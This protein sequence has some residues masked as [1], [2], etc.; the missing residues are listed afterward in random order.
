MILKKIIIKNIRSYEEQEITFPKGSTLLSGN[1]GSG[2]TTV[3][4]AI[5]FA[6]FGLQPSQKAASLLRNDKDEGL[7]S[8]EL[9]IDGKD[10]RIDRLLKRSKKSISQDYSALTIEGQKYEESITEIK[11]KIL[12]LL[13]YPKEFSKK[14]NLLYK[15]TVYTP[16]EEMKQIILESNDLRLNTIRHVFGIDKYKRIEDNTTILISKLRELIKILDARIVFLENDKEILKQKQKNLEILKDRKELVNRDYLDKLDIVREKEESVLEIK[17]KIDEKRILETE[18]LKIDVLISEKNRQYRD[19]LDKSNLLRKEIH[20]DEKISIKDEDYDSIIRR[21]K[22]QVEKEREIQ[23]EYIDIISKINTEESKKNEALNL[24]NKIL[25]LQK[26]PICLQNISDEY[27]NNI[28]INSDKEFK[29]AN[30]R[31][32]ELKLSKEQ[33][34]SKIEELKKNLDDLRLKKS[35]MEILRVRIENIIEKKNR[36]TELETQEANIDRELLLLKKRIQE[37]DKSIQDYKKYD[38]IFF[39]RNNDLKKAKDDE[40][41]TAIKI[42]EINKEI[43][44]LEAD[45]NERISVINEKERI[46][47]ESLELKELEFWISEKFLDII[48]HTEKQVMNTLKEEF[49]KFF[50]SWCSILVS[51]T[52]SV[53]IDNDF[54]PIIEYQDYELDYS[55]LSGGERTAIALSYR[56]ALNQIINSLL[57]NIKTSDIIILDEP[58]DGFSSQQLD[59]MR[60]VL[61]QLNVNQLILVSHETIVEGFVDNIIKIKKE[62]GMSFVENCFVEGVEKRT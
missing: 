38:D 62:N 50:S 53:R 5:E 4:L 46:R 26:C 51:D 42:A 13:N 55:Y 59:K 43:Q 60:D 11:S 16:Q 20:D 32:S 40:N 23:K 25:S 12:D 24:K 31:V 58:T 1:I 39:E 49:S 47:K 2:K 9:E 28:I 57:S 37:L 8:L 33:Y 45:I 56:L 44:F 36:L 52:L 29:Y 10:I 27:K 18:K 54:S 34:I 61:S 6:L 17:E 22:F 48:L 35:N 19:L 7:V 21:I 30:E 15:F 14:T 3:L 41:L